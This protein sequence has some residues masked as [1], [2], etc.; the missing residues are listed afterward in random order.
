MPVVDPP[1][2]VPFNAKLLLLH[3]DPPVP[4]LTV[5]EGVMITFAVSFAGGQTPL[6]VEVKM[7]FTDPLLISPELGV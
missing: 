1:I 2:T 4:A 5:G 7:R 3:I 6:A